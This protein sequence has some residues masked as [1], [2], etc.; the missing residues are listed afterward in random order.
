[1]FKL[2]IKNKIYSRLHLHFKRFPKWRIIGRY[3]N[4]SHHDINDVEAFCII[5]FIISW[6]IAERSQGVMRRG[7]SAIRARFYARVISRTWK[8]PLCNF[9]PKILN[10]LI[11]LPRYANVLIILPGDSATPVHATL[12]LCYTKNIQPLWNLGSTNFVYFMSR[13]DSA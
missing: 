2:N 4:A 9:L 11:K 8:L 5:T 6:C 12:T 13:R 1:M 7:R 10:R 3:K